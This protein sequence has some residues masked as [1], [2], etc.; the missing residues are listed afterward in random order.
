MNRRT[1]LESAV[2]ASIYTLGR[3]TSTHAEER[4]PDNGQEIVIRPDIEAGPLSHFWEECVGSDRAIVAM[5]Q[6]WLVDLER[7]KKDTGMKSVRFHGLFN[8]EMGVWPSHAKAPNFLYVDKVFDTM[9]ALGVKPLVELSFMPADLASGTQTAFF[10]RGN[11]TPP[12]DMS[13]WGELIR[14]FA[15]HCIERYGK[16]EVTSWNF[17]VWNEPNLRY[18]WTGTQAEY[19]ELYRNAAKALKSVDPDLRVGGPA[20]AQ[21]GWVADLLEFCSSNHV[22]IDFVSSH[23]YPDDPQ[24]K[25]FGESAPHYTFEEVIPQAL[26]KLKG[27]IKASATPNLPLYITEWCSQNP[28]FIAHTIKGCIGLADIFSYWT[29]DN[30]FEEM[31]VPTKFM[32]ANFGLLGMDGIPRPSFHT[33]VLLH[34]LGDTQVA[35][36]QGAVLATRRKDGSLAVLVW[37][38][39]PQPPGRRSA[40]G[41]PMLQTAVQD[42]NDGEPK[43]VVLR[44]EGK[45]RGR[46]AQ[47]TRVDKENGNLGRAYQEIGSPQYPTASQI[48]ELKRKSELSKPQVLSLGSRGEIS[49]TIPPN[50][51]ALVELV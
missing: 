27:Q 23:I 34:R 39:I 12:K 28:A 8:D 11:T 38:L 36:D 29:F 3:G 18:F 51:V 43:T 15:S 7:V 32:N 2:V 45:H 33:F 35:T 17:E 41:D 47:V 37:N 26:M 19:F 44:F 40:T 42:S 1:F 31:G 6:Q 20:T 50:G 25:V 30:V 22:P 4:A 14:A 21:A 5:R 9:L 48:D 49:L 46:R 10:Y 16:K 13:Q 24:T